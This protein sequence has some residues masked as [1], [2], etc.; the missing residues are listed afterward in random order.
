MHRIIV[1]HSE[2]STPTRTEVRFITLKTCVESWL[3]LADMTQNSSFGVRKDLRIEFL[4]RQ[5]SEQ[6]SCLLSEQQT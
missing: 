6:K 2:Y 4:Q 3:N 1:G 5:S